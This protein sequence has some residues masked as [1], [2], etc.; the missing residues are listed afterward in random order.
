LLRLRPARAIALET[1][2]SIHRRYGASLCAR[3]SIEVA[4]SLGLRAGFDGATETAGATLSVSVR[5]LSVE[6][7]ADMHAV[8]GVSQRMCLRWDR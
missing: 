8:L 1:G 6:V 4:P 7:G 5:S 2:V 3:A